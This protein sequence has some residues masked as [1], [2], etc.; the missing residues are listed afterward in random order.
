MH[1]DLR[2]P[3]NRPNRDRRQT[4]QA[5]G[6]F[7][8]RLMLMIG[9]LIFVLAMMNEARKPE[10]YHWLTKLQGKPTPEVV[11]PKPSRAPLRGSKTDAESGLKIIDI[12]DSLPNQ[13]RN[14][15]QP[16]AKTGSPETA[17]PS[18]EMKSPEA[19]EAAPKLELSAGPLSGESLPDISKSD[20]AEFWKQL[21]GVLD[22]SERLT[23]FQLLR[24]PE[25]DASSAP[26]LDSPAALNLIAKLD[27]KFVELVSAELDRSSKAGGEFERKINQVAAL[28][29][30]KS[31]WDT[32]YRPALQAVAEARPVDATLRQRLTAFRRTVFE[33]SACL[34]EDASEV[35]R[36]ADSLAWLLAWQQ[37]LKQPIGATTTVT[38]FELMT[39]PRQF[40]ARP[41]ALSGTLRGIETAPANQ[42][43]LG[44]S[45]YFVLWIQPKELDRTP[46]CVYAAELPAELQPNSERFELTRQPITVRG[47]FWKVRSYVD[48]SGAVA[49]CPLI[50]ARNVIIE[51]PQAAAEPYRWKPPA[52]L[53]WTI[54][55]GL[56]LVAFGIAWRIYRTGR[57]FLLPRSPG[58]TRSIH[59]TLENLKTDESIESDRQRLARLEQASE[60]EA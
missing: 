24:L 6:G 36:P 19:T 47:L 29:E 59:A 26:P 25:E 8:A 20:L 44:I 9:L 22:S 10:N 23:L 54:T 49:T 27:Q 16:G 13:S 41:V 30:F 18:S 17:E 31:N 7:R 55:L 15:T 48:T 51:A 60:N 46:Y 1:I 35:A 58:R 11:Q 37:L 28:L 39:Q 38:S 42:Q 4:Y 32:E 21:F 45:E 3:T 40:R 33:E 50:L 57:E 12:T 56:P 53:L 34:L 14:L 52:W 5:A 2:R 43:E